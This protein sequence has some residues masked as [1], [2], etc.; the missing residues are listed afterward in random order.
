MCSI[1]GWYCWGDARPHPNRLRGLLLASQSRG[2]SATGLAYQRGSSIEVI[3]SAGPAENFIFSVPGATWAAV[4]QSPRGLLHARATTKG[5]EDNNENNHPVVAFGWNVV[6]NGQISN[7]DELFSHYKV[8]RFAE[9]DTAAVPLVLSQG[10]AFDDSRRYLTLLGGSA[11]LAIWS[12]SHLDTI[13]LAKLGHNDVYLFLDN[14]A[15]ILYW[16]SASM[17]GRVMPG[18]RLGS[19]KFVTLG[20]LGDDRIMVLRPNREDCVTYKVI[21]SPFDPPRRHL[22]PAQTYV[23]YAAATKEVKS[24][25]EVAAT[26]ARIKWK[27]SRDDPASKN[28]PPPASETF[29]GEWLNKTA[30]VERFHSSDKVRLDIPTAYGRWHITA[31]T[32]GGVPTTMFAP[33]KRTKLFWRT[34]FDKLID[35]PYRKPD[36]E[37]GSLDGRRSL[38]HF[39]IVHTECPGS[40][41]QKLGFVCPWCGVWNPSWAWQSDKY[42][43]E[44]C[45]IVSK[46]YSPTTNETL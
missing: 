43:C 42:R 35:L 12:E 2:I 17:A 32:P 23:P 15:Q 16:C 8:E 6:H 41:F 1:G 19:S 22:W 4:A 21:R 10:E 14:D 29:T 30:I 36:K 24:P 45:N 33:Y 46:P 9:V 25:A 26:G 28:A 44:W 38:E 18:M 11:S 34:L 40:E 27:W 7:D 5:S 20:K 39:V 13:A 31:E 37:V 3:K